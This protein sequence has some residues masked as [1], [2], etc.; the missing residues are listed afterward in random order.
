ME[1]EINLAREH[2]YKKK[3]KEYDDISL[4]S[5]YSF[6]SSRPMNLQEETAK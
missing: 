5:N 3:K 4:K 2:T 6:Y 1:T